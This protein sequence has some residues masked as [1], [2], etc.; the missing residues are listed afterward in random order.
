M[1]CAVT[2]VPATFK[3][4]GDE[5]GENW[6]ANKWMSVSDFTKEVR[7]KGEPIHH[8]EALNAL[9]N[10][11]PP[12]TPL[13]KL[14]NEK[15][16]DFLRYE[17]STEFLLSWAERFLFR[18]I[19]TGG[20]ELRA[21]VQGRWETADPNRPLQYL[22][23]IQWLLFASC[24]A[25]SLAHADS[26]GLATIIFSLLGS[27]LWSIC[28]PSVVGPLSEDAKQS[29]L[30]AHLLPFLSGKVEDMLD[31]KR[32]GRNVHAFWDNFVT[33]FSTPRSVM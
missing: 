15:D 7:R 25:S 12:D 6:Q 22:T 18:D 2:G 26:N 13:S 29:Y 27:K 23:A 30:I 19:S 14:L 17:V 31:E 21:A 3:R 16:R 32:S 11:L 4:D 1:Q 9:N 20:C 33:V 5:D 28:A 8:R 10:Y 24:F